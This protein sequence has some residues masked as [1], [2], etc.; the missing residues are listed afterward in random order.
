VNTVTCFKVT[1]EIKKKSGSIGNHSKERTV[2]SPNLIKE[3]AL[4]KRSFKCPKPIFSSK[5]LAPKLSHNTFFKQKTQQRRQVSSDNVFIGSSQLKKERK[6][7]FESKYDVLYLLGS[8]SFGKVHKV[9]D[10]STNEFRAVKIISKTK[11]NTSE[12]FNEEI[13]ILK[14][15]VTFNITVLGSS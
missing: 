13:K 1:S 12:K 4:A 7:L 9:C 11:C 14:K 5:K 3:K 8:G 10:I 15:L 2:S 6:G